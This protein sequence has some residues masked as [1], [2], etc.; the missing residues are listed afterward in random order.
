MGEVSGCSA[1]KQQRLP[2]HKCTTVERQQQDSLSLSPTQCGV[3]TLSLSTLC[4]LLAASTLASAR[5]ISKSL[6]GAGDGMESL[7][8]AA[9]SDAADTCTGG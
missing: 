1:C 8:A 9:R 2:T 3:H 7:A 5:R 4:S 6:P